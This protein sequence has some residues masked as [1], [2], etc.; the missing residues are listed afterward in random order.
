[1]TGPMTLDTPHVIYAYGHRRHSDGIYVGLTVESTW[2]RFCTHVTKA[3][4]WAKK[5]G[6]AKRFFSPSHQMYNLWQRHGLRD[7][8]VVPLEVLSREPFL[9]T[10]QQFKE[11]H[12]HREIEWYRDIA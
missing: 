6:E 4:E 3:K 9:G 1:M 5:P 10:G 7:F 11:L 12:E 2:K 8:F